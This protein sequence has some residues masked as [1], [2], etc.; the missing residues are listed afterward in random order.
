MNVHNP[1]QNPASPGGDGKGRRKPRRT[2]KGR[3]IDP[4]ALAEVQALLGDCADQAR[5]ADRVSASHSGQ[6]RPHLRGAHGGARVR[7]EARADRGL[8]GRD[9]LFALRRGEGG[10]DAASAGHGARV[11]LAVVLDGGRGASVEVAAAGARL[12][13]ARHSCAVHGRVR[14]RAGLRRRSYAGVPGDAG[15]DDQGCR[16]ACAS[17]C[18]AQAH[19]SRTLHGGRRLQGS[20]RGAER[21]AHA[22]RCHQ[23][24]QRRW[25]SRPRRCGLPDRTQVDFRARGKRPAPDGG[26]LRRGRARHVQGSLLS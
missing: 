25:A 11:Q 24:R 8:R 16:R 10:R 3:Q 19:R 14:S 4:V 21:Q 23:D 13:R 6:V 18:V 20:R 2:P 26:E 15:E 17:A 7:D 12:G 1:P 5:P 9:V 22:R